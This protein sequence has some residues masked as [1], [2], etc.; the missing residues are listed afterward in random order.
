MASGVA[1]STYC[2]N[3]E[4]KGGP[5]QKVLT[6]CQKW[7][8]M[9]QL[10]NICASLSNLTFSQLGSL[11]QHDGSYKIGKCLHPTFLWDG[12]DEFSE[13]EIPRGPFDNSQEFYNALISGL[14]AHVKELPMEHHVFRAPVPTRSEYDDFSTYR[15]ATDRWNDYAT[16]GSKPESST[17]RL[18]YVSAALALTDLVPALTAQDTHFDST[19][20]PLS[21]PDLSTSNIFVDDQLNITCIIDW[22]FAS[23]LPPAMFFV[24][25]GLPHARDGTEPYLAQG[26]ADGFVERR[27][28]GGQMDLPISRGSLFWNLTRLVTF[29]ALQ[30][31]HYFSELLYDLTGQEDGYAL[32]NGLNDRAEFK[33]IARSLSEYDESNPTQH[34]HA[35]EQRYFACVGFERHAIA[36]HLN[37]MAQLNSAFVADR[38]LWC[39]IGLYL[40]E[41]MTYMFSEDLALTYSCSLDFALLVIGQTRRYFLPRFSF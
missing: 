32:L 8:I 17:N 3:E 37:V 12:R 41:R 1:L 38:R 7:H 4:F 16:M 19:G 30:D 2:W 28:F 14:L 35:E 9:K 33:H 39:W 31:Y 21:H 29:D 34:A 36:R 11:S 40:D 15:T 26:F 25:P 10:G 23:S 13:N 27:G 20:F 18:D 5:D 22:A 6:E 24:T